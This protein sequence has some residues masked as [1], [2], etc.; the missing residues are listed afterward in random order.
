[1][2]SARLSG[3]SWAD[4]RGLRTDDEPG[5]PR[6]GEYLVLARVLLA[7]H[8]PGQ[9]L[10]LLDRLHAQAAAQGRAGS[11]IEVAA[12]QALAHAADGDQ[13]AAL[14]ALAEAVAAAGPEGYARVFADEGPPMARLLSRL[15]AAQRSGRIALPGTVPPG[16]L[17]GLSR[18]FKPGAAPALPR[19]TPGAAEAAGLS[20]RELQVLERLAEGKSNQQ[21]AGELVVVPDTVKKHVAHIPAKLAAANRTQAVAR[22]RALG[23]LR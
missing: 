9:A 6:E 20:D 8:A 5:Y 14:A 16:Y 18:A 1:M 11:V 2:R 15:A 21:I 19:T 22:A 23:L 4:E 12:L 10:Q 17:D 7:Q 13:D 3:S